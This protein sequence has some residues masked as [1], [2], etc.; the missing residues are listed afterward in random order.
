MCRAFVLYHQCIIRHEC[1][2]RALLAPYQDS[3][4]QAFS[5]LYRAAEATLIPSL[6]HGVL[7]PFRTPRPRQHF[8]RIAAPR[9]PTGDWIGGNVD[10]Q[11]SPCRRWPGQETSG[12]APLPALAVFYSYQCY[13]EVA[14]L[15][16]KYQMTWTSKLNTDK[17]YSPNE[18]STPTPRETASQ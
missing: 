6:H 4:I 16:P 11:N 1:V 17:S 10:D 3:Q 8:A 15:L 14:R 9:W 2:H 7:A 12:G 13:S 5:E 18:V